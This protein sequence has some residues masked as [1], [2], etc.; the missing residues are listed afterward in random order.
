MALSEAKKRANIAYN[1]RQDSITI[2]PS[3]EEG[4]VIRQ[5]AETAG[6]ALQAY[7]LQAVRERMER[8]T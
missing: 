2:R 7:I 6:Q 4:A 1:K 5:A 3:K 8:N